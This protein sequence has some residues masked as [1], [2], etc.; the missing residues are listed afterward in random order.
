MDVIVK[1]R[2][3]DENLEEDKGVQSKKENKDG[4]ND[5]SVCVCTDQQLSACE[6]ADIYKLTDSAKL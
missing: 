1:V 4:G 6:I 5:F 2:D 3:P